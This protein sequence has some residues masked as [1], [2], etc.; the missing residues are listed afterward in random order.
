[1]YPTKLSRF[2]ISLLPA[3]G[4]DGAPLIRRAELSRAGTNDKIGITAPMVFA[5]G[6]L[7][8]GGEHALHISPS[9]STIKV[10]AE[11]TLVLILFS[12]AARLRLTSLRNDMGLPVRLLGIG[13]TPPA[14]AIR[15]VQLVETGS[16]TLLSHVDDL[17]NPVETYLT[18][19]P[20]HVSIT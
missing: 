20:D 15:S 18:Y 2:S 5:I 6:G 10:T 1:M 7:A 19:T 12:D 14:T 3:F 4:E 17:I 13:L 8:L 16:W 9:A 11:I